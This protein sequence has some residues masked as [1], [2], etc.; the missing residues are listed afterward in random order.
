M[1]IKSLIKTLH[2]LERRIVPYLD[3]YNNLNDLSTASGLKEVE[4]ARA[5]QWLENKGAIKLKE[6]LKEIVTLDKNGKKYLEEGLPERRLLSVLKGKNLTI[7][8]AREKSKLSRDEVSI[9]IGVLRKNAAIF[10]AKEKDFVLKL[11]EN[12]ER[13]LKKEMLEEQFL[14]KEFP[15][16][17]KNLREEERFAYENLKKRK[18]I[19][20]TEV[21]KTKIVSLTD[22]G[23][24]LL[25]Q[26]ITITDVVDTI[27][28]QI[29]RQGLWK[30]KPLRRYDIKINVPKIYGGREHVVN[31]AIEYIKKIWIELGFQEMEGNLVQTAFWDLDALF[32]PQDHP[33]RTMQDTFYIKK[34]KYGKLPDKEL[35][36][37]VKETH[38]KGWTTGSNGWQYAWNENVAKEN[39]LRTHTTVL[40]ARTLSRLKKEDLPAKFFSVGKVF[41]NETVDW[42]HLFEL[43]QVEGIVV[44]PHAN[45]KHLLGYLKE[46]FTKMGYLDVRIRPAHFPYT[47]PSAEVEV[48]HP[49]KKQWIELGGAGIF[50]PEVT[51]PLLGFECPVLAWGLG[52][53]RTISDY[54]QINDIRDLYKNDLKQLREIKMWMK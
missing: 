26:K 22:L 13:L 42:K 15:V 34:P 17:V 18:E 24:Q 31:Q 48:L 11:M 46:F 51:K 35:V 16:E 32:V 3:K 44:D 27:T 38:E 47:E 50:R 1:D 25:E 43:T 2:H 33:A 28:P 12:G 7:D 19:I 49:I 8:Q 9:A 45:F 20:K 37:R 23:K 36:K 30:T 41:R 54:F 5:L 6:E 21:K 4:T 10:V 40:S 53:E 52:L 39:L 29:L 14:K